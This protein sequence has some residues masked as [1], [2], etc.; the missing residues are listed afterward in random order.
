MVENFCSKYFHGRKKLLSVLSTTL[1]KSPPKDSLT[2]SNDLEMLL[3]IVMG[4]TKNK[5]L[6][7][8]ALTTS[9]MSTRPI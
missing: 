7:K 3:L 1:S 4:S 9:L 5:S 8:S 6:W 2:S